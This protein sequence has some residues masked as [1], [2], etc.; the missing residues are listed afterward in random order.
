MCHCYSQVVR[1]PLL[2]PLSEEEE[3]QAIK[4][5]IWGPTCDRQAPTGRALF[6][7]SGAPTATLLVAH[8]PEALLGARTSLTFR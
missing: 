6:T 4:S 2:P 7:L 8:L 5:T 3:R 1:S